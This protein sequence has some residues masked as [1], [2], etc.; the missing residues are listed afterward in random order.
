MVTQYLVPF[1]KVEVC[2]RYWGSSWLREY[3]MAFAF[4]PHGNGQAINWQ[5]HIRQ[6]IL[7]LPLIESGNLGIFQLTFY[8]DRVSP[9]CFITYVTQNALWIEFDFWMKFASKV[10]CCCKSSFIFKVCGRSLNKVWSPPPLSPNK[11]TKQDFWKFDHSCFSSNKAAGSS[12]RYKHFRERPTTSH[13][14]TK[15]LSNLLA[16]LFQIKDP[17]ACTRWSNSIL[18]RL[19]WGVVST[20]SRSYQ[21]FWEASDLFK[22]KS[23]PAIAK[24]Y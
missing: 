22:G 3:T 21:R 2:S 4:L 14:R 19:E 18:G 24:K 20:Q 16:H 10:L 13:F 15:L 7:L 6:L 11:T 17:S 9:F 5:L 23:D 8:R 12:A 1:A